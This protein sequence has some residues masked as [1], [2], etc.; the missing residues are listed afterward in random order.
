MR[1]PAD[2]RRR[3]GGAIAVRVLAVVAGVAWVTVL[4][5]VAF[6]GRDHGPDVTVA[7][8]ESYD[9]DDLRR[10]A[11]ELARLR[12]TRLTPREREAVGA[13]AVIVDAIAEGEARITP[14]PAPTTTPPASTTTS[15]TTTAP[16]PPPPPTAPPPAAPEPP[17]RPRRVQSYVDRL[18]DQLGVDLP[19]G[20]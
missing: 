8:V 4:F 11:D 16:P 20:P 10:V 6:A 19:G 13:A 15:T 14:A 5:L 12:G 7:P 18:A 3:A 1:S 17:D 2:P 9:S